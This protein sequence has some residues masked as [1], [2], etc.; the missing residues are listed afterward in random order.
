MKRA[1]CQQADAL[2]SEAGTDPLAQVGA[3]LAASE[4]RKQSDDKAAS[5]IGEA[6]RRADNLIAAARRQ[7]S[8]R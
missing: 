3:K 4:L 6:S 5:I 1:G 8:V 2:I 7:A